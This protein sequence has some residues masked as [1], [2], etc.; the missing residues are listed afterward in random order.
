MFCPIYFIW[1]KLI[2]KISTYL[3]EYRN[4]KLNGILLQSKVTYT[5]FTLFHFFHIL[6]IYQSLPKFL[7]TDPKGDL[8]PGFDEAPPSISF[9]V[10]FEVTGLGPSSHSLIFPTCCCYSMIFAY[11][12]IALFCFLFFIMSL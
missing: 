8:E 11:S 12:F 10:F 5:L 9:I 7:T 6:S 2:W 1:N 3:K 4:T